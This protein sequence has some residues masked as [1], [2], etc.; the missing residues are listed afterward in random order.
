L[1]AFALIKS[2]PRKNTNK[3]S[4]K[5]KQKQKQKKIKY[6]VLWGEFEVKY[7]TYNPPELSNISNMAEEDAESS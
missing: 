5:Q 7:V 2:F 4:N 1:T 6:F 3:E